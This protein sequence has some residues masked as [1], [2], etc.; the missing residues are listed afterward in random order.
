M[1]ETFPPTDHSANSAPKHSLPKDGLPNDGCEVDHTSLA[2]LTDAQFEQ[3][4]EIPLAHPLGYG[5]LRP[6]LHLDSLPGIQRWRTVL[7]IDPTEHDW[8]TLAQ[9]V[10]ETLEHQS[11][12]STDVRWLKYVLKIALGK[13]FFAPGMRELAEEIIEFPNKGDMR[14]VRPSIRAAEMTIRRNPP[15]AWIEKYWSELLTKTKCIDGSSEADYFEITAPTLTKDTILSA[16]SQIAQR[17]RSVMTSTRTDAKLD[18]AFGFTLYALSLLEEIAAPPLSQLLLGRI[19]LRSIA[20]VVIT[21][22]YLL[23]KNDPTLWATYRSF[24][25]GQAKLAFLKLEQATG[26]APAFVNQE[27]LFQLANE[28]A[29]QEFVNVN[30]GHWN[31]K[32]LRDLAIEGGT[33]DIYDRYYDWASTF[34]HGHWCAVRDS[35]FVTCHN[36]LHR[37]HRIPRPYHRIMPTV[38]PDAVT[39][40]NRTIDLLEAAFPTMDKLRRI[41]SAIPHNSDKPTPNQNPAS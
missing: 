26:D 33:K 19:G 25:S 16:R 41:E 34:V 27:T 32:N 23:R 4:V 7:G 40:V 29:W 12:I 37:L 6:L 15:S 18:A 28:D 17:F 2:Q 38:V 31:N 5:A 30:F 20:E 1:R 22:S 11:E 39:L 35:N 14:S 9:A 21:F 8:K 3:F 13:V 24:G 10:I 36:A